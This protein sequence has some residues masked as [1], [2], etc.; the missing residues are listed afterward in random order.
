MRINLNYV[1]AYLVDE[2]IKAEAIVD[3]TAN[4][5]DIIQVQLASGEHVAIHLV[6][7][8]IDLEEIKRI[9]KI[10][11]NDNFNT[12][13]ILWNS[14]LL[15]DEGD[16]YLP[17][18]WMAA[19]YTLYNDKIYAYESYGP[20]I[21]IF[22][23]HFDIQPDGPERLIRYG[24]PVEMGNLGCD[25]VHTETLHLKGTWR[26]ADFETSTARINRRTQEPRKDTGSHDAY[27]KNRRSSRSSSLRPERNPISAYY[28][29]LGIS[30]DSDAVTVRKAYHNL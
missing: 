22:P 5:F 15:P 13:F 10:N 2:L 3:I 20:D 23:V 25:T 16:L 24:D 26:I 19:L 21:V 7:R 29:I 14:M 30:L 11:S 18:D 9:L 12:L 27:R 28:D 6:E 4:G 17:Y 1:N 8:D